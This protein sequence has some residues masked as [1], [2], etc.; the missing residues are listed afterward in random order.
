M[1]QITLTFKDETIASLRKRLRYVP[2]SVA[3]VRS[4]VRHAVV[5]GF[6]ARKTS[7]QSIAAHRTSRQRMLQNGQYAWAKRAL[8][9]EFPDVIEILMRQ[10][11]EH[12]FGFAVR[13]EWTPDDS[14]SV[15]GVG[16]G[17]RDRSERRSGADRHAR[18]AD[19]GGRRRYSGTRAK[20]AD[21]GMASR[22]FNC[23]HAWYETKIATEHSTGSTAREKLGELRCLLR[24][25]IFHGSIAKQEASKCS[26]KLRSC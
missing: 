23:V 18:R 12:G 7:R 5:R 16:D 21:A 19:Q 26:N 2:A 20:D 4:A 8:D 22:R 3:Q 15:A 10:A 1:G 6:P 17:H 9:K 11:A 24:L 13:S 14:P 25:G